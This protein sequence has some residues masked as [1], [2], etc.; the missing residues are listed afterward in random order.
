L[1]GDRIGSV[2]VDS[3]ANM[4]NLNTEI[5]ANATVELLGYHSKGDGGGGTFYWDSASTEDD[6]GGTIIEATGVVDGRWIRNY[7]GAVNVKWF[8]AVGDGVVDDSAAFQNALNTASLVKVPQGVYKLNSTITLGQ[9]NRL[10]GESKKF[11]TNIQGSTLLFGSG[12]DVGVRINVVSVAP[13]FTGGLE[14]LALRATDYNTTL[15]NLGNKDNVIAGEGAWTGTIKDCSFDHANIAILSSH[16]QSFLIE[17]NLFKDIPE[18]SIQYDSTPSSAFITNNQFDMSN[19]SSQ[20]LT[21]GIRT[22]PGTL[23]GGSNINIT[24][25]YFLNC[26]YGVWISGTI[27]S[28]INNNT[29]ELCSNE[30]IY[31]NKYDWVGGNSGET[32]SNVVSNNYFIGWGASATQKAAIKLNTVYNNTF[33]G[34]GFVSPWGAGTS[35]LKI[36]DFYEAV[37]GQLKNNNIEYPIATGTNSEYAK[38]FPS[39]SYIQKQ[40]IQGLKGIK[41]PNL[42]YDSSGLDS[43]W[44]GMIYKRDDKDN[45]V[46]YHQN[47]PYHT[48]IMG[49]GAIVGTAGAVTDYVRVH[50]DGVEYALPLHALS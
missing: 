36:Y 30:S 10:V 21:T 4:K 31:L 48:E 44:D 7:S 33:F 25:N 17:G 29:F 50:I 43:N 39:N 24:H 28:L 45:P 2:V 12:V 8:G 38:A 49:A 23:G 42:P 9:C 18:C 6:N 14:N 46:I 13:Y 15:V 32:H 41:M 40:F 26:K 11:S 34:N 1:D 27:G 3:I 35:D 16:S 19:P 5:E 22:K 37:S 20:Y 47:Y